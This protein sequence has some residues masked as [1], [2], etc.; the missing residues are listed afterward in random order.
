MKTRNR[1]M[2]FVGLVIAITL[3]A[4][5][6]MQAQQANFNPEL[7]NGRWSAA[8]PPVSPAYAENGYFNAEI[9]NTPQLEPFALLNLGDLAMDSGE[10]NL[11]EVSELV[12]DDYVPEG[13]SVYVLVTRR[14]PVQTASHEI[15][16]RGK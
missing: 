12:E 6:G 15:A 7:G 11:V 2:T 10:E 1:N 4:T 8:E 16:M 3:L 9:G 14:V 5:S 13:Q